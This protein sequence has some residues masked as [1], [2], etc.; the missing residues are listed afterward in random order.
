MN[1][2][3]ARKFLIQS[4]LHLAQ[5]DGKSQIE[6][7]KLDA[8]IL[9]ACDYFIEKTKLVTKT[10]TIATVSGTVTVDFSTPVAAFFYTDQL[11][12]V[13]HSAA[14]SYTKVHQRDFE[15]IRNRLEAGDSSGKPE[16]MAFLDDTTAYL[17]PT[18]DAVYTLT[19]KYA[20]PVLLAED[21]GDEFEWVAGT[22]R[23]GEIN[24]PDKW[25][26]TIITDGAV[27]HLVGFN[28][29]PW[30]NRAWE[31]YV[32]WVRGMKGHLPNTGVTMRRY[33]Y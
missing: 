9:A 22:P 24:I 28:K 8:A 17:S 31:R 1:V 25:L 29:N 30:A 21:D 13:M 10:T 6:D 27:S 18:P 32:R 19:L 7:D 14:K 26:R 2:Q 20:R 5:A 16:Y 33:V 23:K 3:E 11:L 4:V 15:F 12:S